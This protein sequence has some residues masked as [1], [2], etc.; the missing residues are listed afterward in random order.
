MQ[1]GASA[2]SLNSQ[3][4]L[5]KNSDIANRSFEP[6]SSGLRLETP[7]NEAVSLS[8]ESKIRAYYGDPSQNTLNLNNSISTIQVAQG[9]LNETGGSLQR[10]R[11]LAV[12]STGANYTAEN[13]ASFLEEVEQLKG[14]VDRIA[15]ET[16][17]NGQKLLDGSFSQ[18]VQ[19][20]Q[21]SLNISLS[22]VNTT[23]L[24]IA[25]LDLSSNE[26]SRN[27]IE[28]I[29]QAISTISAQQA[30]LGSFQESL[31]PFSSENSV[32][33]E[34][35]ITSAD[36]AQETATLTRNA[37]LQQADTSVLAQANQSQ[38]RATSLLG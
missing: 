37:I 20:N 6:I 23:G 12:Q 4:A 1:I 27:A 17:Y 7:K 14:N 33:S 22:N 5:S 24:N 8:E 25:N 9:A 29:D 38:Y 18:G 26:G 19:P 31:D 2:A 10:I 13:R 32:S 34:P 30:R 35:R 28:S 21:N 15:S 36:I 11:E 3:Y 16:N